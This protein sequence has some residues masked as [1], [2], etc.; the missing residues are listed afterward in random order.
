MNAGGRLLPEPVFLLSPPRSGSTL[1][2]S[3]LDTHTQIRSPQEL[4]LKYLQV[5]LES[6][7]CR[8]SLQHLGYPEAELRYLLWDRLLHEELR[9]RGKQVLVEKSP[10]NIDILDELRYCWPGARFVVLLRHPRRVARSM[11]GSFPD[12]DLG[13]AIRRL[14]RVDEARQRLMSWSSDVLT[15]N[16]ENLVAYP[17]PTSQRIC[18][19]LGVAYEPEMISYGRRDHGPYLYGLGDWGDRISS[20]VVLPESPA[21]PVPDAPALAAICQR[22]GYEDQPAD[23][24]I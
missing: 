21:G 1:L 20:G 9:S 13:A 15:V 3:I 2:R 12:Y 6:D 23:P 22:W 18:E 8:M 10:C 16:Y 5:R 17:A 7:H 24:G 14:T 11:L 19:Y 4:H